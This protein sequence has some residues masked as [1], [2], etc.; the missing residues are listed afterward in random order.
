MKGLLVNVY[1]NVTDLGNGCSMNLFSDHYSTIFV[2][3]PGGNWDSEEIDPTYP[4]FVVNEIKGYRFLVPVGEKRHTMA[5]G[6]FAYDWDSR[7]RRHVNEYPI[8]IHDR[9]E[10]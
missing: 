7:F 4:K 9:V 1:R 10:F 5:S 6:N 3:C 2:E 8:M